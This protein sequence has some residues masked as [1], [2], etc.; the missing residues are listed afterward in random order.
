MIYICIYATQSSLHPHKL[1]V[2]SPLSPFVHV[3]S[4]HISARQG[5]QH[6]YVIIYSCQWLQYYITVQQSKSRYVLDNGSVWLK[7]VPNLHENMR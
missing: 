7:H 4:L 6:H 2:E 3:S 5:H 1:L